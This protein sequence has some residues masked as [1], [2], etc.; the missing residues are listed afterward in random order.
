MSSALFIPLRA[1]KLQPP[2]PTR[3]PPP[4]SSAASS[5]SRRMD[6][7]EEQREL[8]PMAT[9]STRVRLAQAGEAVAVSA[10]PRQCLG[11]FQVHWQLF[12]E[13]RRSRGLCKHKRSC[14]I[15][16]F[17]TCLRLLDSLWIPK[18]GMLLQCS[19]TN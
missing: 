13:P 16:S 12:K 14:T 10:V 5:S 3:Q 19:E 15:S 9:T 2:A 11:G 18:K 8:S 17:L 4:S 7:A 6:S 1:K